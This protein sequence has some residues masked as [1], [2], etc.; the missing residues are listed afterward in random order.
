MLPSRP[1]TL[2][3]TLPGVKANTVVFTGDELLR[4]GYRTVGEA[5]AFEAGF[6]RER[7]AGGQR[8]TLYGVQNGIALI[9]DGVPL[10]VDGE[11]D[12]L[13]VDDVLDLLEVERIEV[14][15]G[16]SSTISGAGALTGTVRVTTRR[17]GV[18]G[19]VVRVSGAALVST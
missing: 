13:D 15:K 5:L 14:V 4:R 7:V 10:V 12:V 11:R 17:P 8:Y 18:T 3:L 19:A 1:S 16:P 9:V 6:V 2:P